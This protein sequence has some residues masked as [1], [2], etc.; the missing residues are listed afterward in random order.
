MLQLGLG[1][2]LGPNYRRLGF[3]T[4]IQGHLE[5]VF[6]KSRDSRV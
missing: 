4:V 3:R 5:N 1:L 2:G 6:K